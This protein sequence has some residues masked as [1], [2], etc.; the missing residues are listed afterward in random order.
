VGSG[1]GT[2]KKYIF[3][4]CWRKGTWHRFWNDWLGLLCIFLVCFSQAYFFQLELPSM[5]DSSVVLIIKMS[6]E[7]IVDNET[8]FWGLVSSTSL[9]GLTATIDHMS[10]AGVMF[11]SLC[12]WSV[13][14]ISPYPYPYP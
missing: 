8:C 9:T 7:N 14:F 13:P 3:S 5:E 2:S 1:K 11:L 6:S 10:P 4:I 12:W